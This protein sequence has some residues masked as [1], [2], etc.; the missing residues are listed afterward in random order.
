M[1]PDLLRALRVVIDPELGLDVVS[2]GLIYEASREGDTAKVVMTVTSPACPLGSAMVEDAREAISTMV[3]GLSDI[4]IELVLEP[5][6]TPA[7]LTP[8]A[9]AQL[10]F[11]EAPAARSAEGT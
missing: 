7:R 8:E 6:W 2:L 1:D 5:R 10:G 9:R 3:P 11:A 4:D